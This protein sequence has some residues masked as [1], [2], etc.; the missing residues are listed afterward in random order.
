MISSRG[1]SLLENLRVNGI[2]CWCQ[3]MAERLLIIQRAK[4]MMFAVSTRRLLFAES[5]E[6]HRKK[7]LKERY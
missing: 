4:S 2:M 3:R 1:A 5:F 6:P 7:L